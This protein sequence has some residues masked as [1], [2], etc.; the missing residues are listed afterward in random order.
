MTLFVPFFK[1]IKIELLFF[2]L[3]FFFCLFVSFVKPMI[4]F[5]VINHVY[6]CS[7]YQMVLLCAA[8]AN[9]F[10]G[11][12]VTENPHKTVCTQKAN[13]FD[14]TLAVTDLT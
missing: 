5:R 2:G 11:V 8:C 7:C 12:R 14:L 3:S 1:I 13:G 9:E 6:L 10:K 4:Q